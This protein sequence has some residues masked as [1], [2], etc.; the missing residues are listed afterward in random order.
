MDF[1]FGFPRH[2][3]PPKSPSRPS[4]MAPRWL[5]DAPR[6]APR[7][8]KSRPWPP[9]MAPRRPQAVQDDPKIAPRG[10]L[11]VPRGAKEASK[12]DQKSIRKSIRNRVGSWDGKMAQTLRLPKSRRVG[13]LP[14]PRSGQ[15][16]KL[17][18]PSKIGLVLLYLTVLC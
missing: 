9:K 16:Q 12:I 1:Q 10:T 11:E 4:K 7:P 13:S 3:K 8:P 17:S 18:I 15:G 5:Q 2:P 6:G 14:Q